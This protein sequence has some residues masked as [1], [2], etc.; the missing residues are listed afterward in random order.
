[1][2]KT[3]RKDLIFRRRWRKSICSENSSKTSL[4]YLLLTFGKRKN[5]KSLNADVRFTIRALKN[6]A[7]II[8]ISAPF[9]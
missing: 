2:E 5:I 7:I 3:Q 8:K 6:G 9:A 4:P 1:M